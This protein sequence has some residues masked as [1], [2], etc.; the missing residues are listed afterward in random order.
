MNKRCLAII[1]HLGENST[2]TFWP[3]HKK[4][5]QS[6][7]LPLKDLEESNSEKLSGLLWVHVF[8]FRCRRAGGGRGEKWQEKEG[9]FT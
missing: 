2:T 1:V 9:K 3:V 7:T 6:D 8:N 5:E 4:Y